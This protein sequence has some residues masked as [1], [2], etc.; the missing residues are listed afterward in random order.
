MLHI[1]NWRIIS[2]QCFLTPI[3]SFFFFV[4][5]C[6]LKKYSCYKNK[7]YDA[8]QNN[9]WRFLQLY[10]VQSKIMRRPFLCNRWSQMYTSRYKIGLKN[11]NIYVMTFLNF[12][13][14]FCE[15]YK[16]ELFIQSVGHYSN[17]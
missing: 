9:L 17:I 11:V 16:T 1:I 4:S 8:I 15:N 6:T 2:K 5:I 10:R 14:R 12:K 13:N 7:Y 3:F